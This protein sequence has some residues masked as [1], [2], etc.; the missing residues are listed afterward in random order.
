MLFPLS[1]CQIYPLGKENIKP[2]DPTNTHIDTHMHLF[3]V[4]WLEFGTIQSAAGAGVVWWVRNSL[5]RRCSRWNTFSI[6]MGCASHDQGAWNAKA[7]APQ[8]KWSFGYDWEYLHEVSNYSRRGP[9][10]KIK[11]SSHLK[12]PWT[13]H[14]WN[15]MHVFNTEEQKV[16]WQNFS[17]KGWK[18]P[19]CLAGLL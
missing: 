11:K 1:C 16:F 15:K 5:G 6:G 2:A 10:K 7:A 13:A 14:I 4:K 9:L 18:G 8:V 19:H 17:G 3:P 12:A